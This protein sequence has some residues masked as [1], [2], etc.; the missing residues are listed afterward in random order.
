[1]SAERDGEASP[2]ARFIYCAAT[3]TGLAL[4]IWLAPH[5]RMGPG[6]IGSNTGHL[7]GNVYSWTTVAQN[8]RSLQLV[9][10]GSG[11]T[12]IVTSI[13]WILGVAYRSGANRGG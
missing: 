13:G 6:A 1:M 8:Q 3:A 5:L 7:F 2:W 10:T 9:T 4:G 12:V 11:A